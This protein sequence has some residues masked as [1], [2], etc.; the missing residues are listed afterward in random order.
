MLVTDE[1]VPRRPRVTCPVCGRHVA[2][3]PNG[4]VGRHKDPAGDGYH[5]DGVGKA[6]DPS[7]RAAELRKLAELVWRYPQRA[8]E[9]VA[10]LPGG[11]D[12]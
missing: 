5:C 7:V 10:Q 8:R 1:P 3:Y 11:E 4:N 12:G 9:L 2:L 6:P